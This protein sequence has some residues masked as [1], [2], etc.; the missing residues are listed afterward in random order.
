MTRPPDDD[1]PDLPDVTGDE[2]DEGWGDEPSRRRGDPDDERLLADRPPH[3][4]E[5]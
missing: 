4:S 2:S 5:S 3:W 1:R